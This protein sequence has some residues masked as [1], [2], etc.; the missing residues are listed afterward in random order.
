MKKCNGKYCRLQLSRGRRPALPTG[1]SGPL[2]ARRAAASILTPLPPVGMCEA[3]VRN[4]LLRRPKPRWGF[5]LL[6]GIHFAEGI[7]P[8]KMS[9][10]DNR[11]R[12]LPQG[13]LIR[14]HFI[15]IPYVCRPPPNVLMETN[16]PSV[17]G[18]DDRDRPPRADF[19]PPKRTVSITSSGGNIHGRTPCDDR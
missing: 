1:V 10:T 19:V 3:R 8:N 7:R 5:L 4:G 11:W 9:W 14:S 15:G 12:V 16:G 2:T 6:R 13:V 18:S 17:G